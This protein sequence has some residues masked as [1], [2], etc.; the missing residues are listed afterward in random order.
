MIKIINTIYLLMMVFIH[1]MIKKL[2]SYEDLPN[3]QFTYKIN[4]NFPKYNKVDY[5]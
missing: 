4:L 2:L 3:I 1:L 5:G